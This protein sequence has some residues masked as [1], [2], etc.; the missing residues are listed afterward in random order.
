MNG[1]RAIWPETGAVPSSTS[2]VPAGACAPSGARC[3]NKPTPAQRGCATGSAATAGATG[4][5]AGSARGFGG[6]A[7]GA[8]AGTVLAST[9]VPGAV[10]WQ[11]PGFELALLGRLGRRQ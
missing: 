4:E 5:V 7:L 2:T 9:E 3:T 8:A 10:G 6:A 11:V 1:P